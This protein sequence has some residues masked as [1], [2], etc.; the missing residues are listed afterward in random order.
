[1]NLLVTGGTGYIGSHTC[2]ELLKE[3]HKIVIVDNLS[4]S[5][6]G[7][8]Q[9][10]EAITGK[11]CDFYEAD[12][13]DKNALDTI[14]CKHDIDAV[15]HFAALKAVGESTQKPLL[16]YENNVSGTLT[17]LASMKR[18]GV[19][20]MVFSSSATVYGAPDVV[21]VKEDAQLKPATNP[22]GA[23][24]QMVERIL[25]DEFIADPEWSISILR[26]FN[27]AGADKSG[28]IGE[29]P[30][31]IPNNLLPY[32]AQVAVG[33]LPY[34]KIYGN[35]YPTKDG[36]GI[37]DYIH[38]ID[39]ARG[40]IAAINIHKEDKGV[41]VYN[42]GTGKGSSVLNV[43]HAFEKAAGKKLPYQFEDR[44]SGDI[45]ESYAD[46]SRARTKLNWVAKY[47]IEEMMAD[48]W[49]WQSNNP[50]GITE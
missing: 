10:I 42:L 23:C 14:F 30:K 24:K 19:K 11:T 36:T 2:V 21:P 6:K 7:V 32:I 28:L 31:D 38:V 33:H 45:A 48:A 27:P 16:Y 8:L 3:G 29:N 5:Q 17:L 9:R 50:D 43:L 39:L 26:Y 1:M 15:I 12:I 46:P 4:N 49:H 34:L 18:A 35:N 20:N 37:R 13:R 41:F 40:H 44:R 22:Y 47:T 25:Q